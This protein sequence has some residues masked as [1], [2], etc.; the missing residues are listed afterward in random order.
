MCVG[1]TENY[2]NKNIFHLK[3]LLDA[4]IVVAKKLALF[5]GY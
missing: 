3:M 4:C 2:I 5:T 1:N